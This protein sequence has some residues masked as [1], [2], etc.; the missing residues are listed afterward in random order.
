MAYQYVNAL[1]A[2]TNPLL[3]I[4]MKEISPQGILNAQVG[5]ATMKLMPHDAAYGCLLAAPQA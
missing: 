5:W 4:P 3:M 1:H 2:R